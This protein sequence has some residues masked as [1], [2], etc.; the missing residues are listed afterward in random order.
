MNIPNLAG[1][2][3]RDPQLGEALKAISAA[4]D[5]VALQ[6]NANPQGQPPKPPQVSSLV[7]TASDGIFHGQITDNNPV[8]RGITYH[9]EASSTPNFNQPI[10]LASG[11]SRDKAGIA[12]GNQKLYFRAFSQYPTGDPSA[13]VYHGGSPQNP[14]AVA[15][16]GTLAGP[17]VLTSK[18]SGTA[19]SSG[20]QGGA[21]FGFVQQR[22]SGGPPALL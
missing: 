16:G 7:V 18:G 10:L 11:P 3:A 8:A 4:M 14:V 1:I 5:T 9:L 13:P 20:T 19:P 6:T 21:G 15:G 12:L 2:I 22:Q 17:P